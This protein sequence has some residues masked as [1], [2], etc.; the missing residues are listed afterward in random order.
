M[1]DNETALGWSIPQEIMSLMPGLS[2]IVV[3]AQE[4]KEEPAASKGWVVS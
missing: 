2:V 4:K 1:I 3:S